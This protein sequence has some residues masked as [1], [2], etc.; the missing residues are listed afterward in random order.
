LEYLQE[1]VNIKIDLSK[2][3]TSE[4]RNLLGVGLRNYVGQLQTAVRVCSA[5]GKT[6]AYN[7]YEDKLPRFKLK[8]QL[9]L[10]E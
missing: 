9:K 1:L 8:L 4:E 2:D 10:K 6:K 3:F 5:I 7:K